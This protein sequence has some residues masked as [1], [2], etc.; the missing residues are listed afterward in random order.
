MRRVG[1]VAVISVLL[2]IS[3][4]ARRSHQNAAPVESIPGASAVCPNETMPL[5]GEVGRVFG[6]RLFAV[7]VPGIEG[8][9]LVF[10]PGSRVAAVRAG[11]PV[12]ILGAV[13]PTL[14]VDLEHEWGSF[15]RDRSPA[16]VYPTTLV[17][18]R[19]ASRMDVIISA[20]Q[21][22][23]FPNTT[24]A[25]DRTLT[26]VDML[27]NSTGTELVGQ[28]VSLR[29]VRITVVG[30]RRGFWISSDSEELFVLPADEVHPQPGQRVN[31][32]GVVLQLPDGMMNRLG[33]YSAARD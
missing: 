30:S 31:L 2:A 8:E 5:I 6:P 27:A 14:T 3:S 28:F 22:A 33:D 32:K 18:E 10:V 29:N 9:T 11:L 7:I 23:T 1:S 20:A 26:D 17:A 12:C 13:S 15:E 19:V 25:A 4:E 16:N 24:S 21:H